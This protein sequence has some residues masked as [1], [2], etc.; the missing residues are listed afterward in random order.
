MISKRLARFLPVS[1]MIAVA[2][3]MVSVMASAVMGQSPML[4]SINSAHTG[5]GNGA[6][7]NTSVSAD[8]RFVV[9]ES[10]SSDLASNDVNGQNP[11]VFLWDAQTGIVKLI[12]VGPSGRGSSTGAVSPVI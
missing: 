12:S 2:V 3:M 9:F 5:N 8:G 1:V 7:R 11:D 10:E 6:S 4:V